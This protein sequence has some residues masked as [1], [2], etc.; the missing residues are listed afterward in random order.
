MDIY[1][2]HQGTAPLLVSLPHDGS[3]LPDP[4]AARLTAS[5]RR[6]PD[7]DWHV[8]RL[9]DFARELGAS[10]LVPRYSRYVVDLNRPPDDTSLYPGQN[11][12]GLCP[13]VQFSGEP[14]YLEGA[15]PDPAEIAARVDTYWRPYHDTLDAELQRIRGEHGRAVLWEGHSIRGTLPFLFDGAL[16]ELNLGT[17]AGASCTPA[18]QQRLADVLAAQS[19]HT[20]VVNGRFKG[21]YITR[22]YGDPEIGVEAV[23]LEIA[24]H[25]YMDEVSFEYLPEKAAKLQRVIRA[26]LEAALA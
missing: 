1:H 8:S 9:Y 22:H 25:A 24:Q 21:G 14:V 16:P 11:T 23:Q 19:E 10:I 15:Q 18:L 4:I 13:V 17:A 7:T 5:A 20:H 26:L 6:T 12:T 2:L 3:A